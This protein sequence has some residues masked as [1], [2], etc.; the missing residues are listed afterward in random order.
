MPRSSLSTR[1]LA[2]LALGGIP[3][4]PPC[5]AE[6]AAT[7]FQEPDA[8]EVLPKGF[9]IP[10]TRQARALSDRA[11]EHVAARRYAEAIADLQTLIVEHQGDVLL[12][13]RG[14]R[15]IP[16]CIHVGAAEWARRE[17]LALPLAARATYRDRFEVD[18]R[19]AFER[20]R[21]A[22]SRR[23]LIEVAR[24]YPLC[25]AARDAWWT[26]GDL[27]LEQGDAA[28]AARAYERAV[29]LSEALGEP[30]AATATARLQL[31]R[32]L[33][34]PEPAA[35]TSPGAEC[36][37]WQRRIDTPGK[38][39]PFETRHGEFFNLFPTAA[40]DLVL[41]SD[42]LRLSAFDAWS[43]EPRWTSAE[44]PGWD[45]VDAGAYR[46]NGTTPIRR[47][48]FFDA[49]DRRSLVVRPAAGGGV[50]VAALQIPVSHGYRT[51]FQNYAIT[52]IIPDRR[53]FAFELESGRE[54][55]NHVPPTTWDGESGSFT[56]RMRV[57]GP[58]VISGG[59]VLAPVY[60]MQG[61]VEMHVACFDLYDGALLW[62]T[63]LVSGQ[64]E[65]NMFG[66]QQREFS[67][68]PVALA[69]DRAIALTQ[70]GAIAALDLE[71]GEILW[72]TLYD[73]IELPPNEGFGPR[74]PREQHWANG[75]ALIA[76]GVAIAAPIDSRFVIGLDL[77]TGK[78]LW[79]RPYTTF[80]K[81]R[82]SDTL[83]TLLGAE[84]DTLWIGGRKI[85]AARSLAGLASAPGPAVVAES[86]DL[87]ETSGPRPRAALTATHVIVPTPSRRVA[88]ERDGLGD[89]DPRLSA[90]WGPTAMQGNAVAAHGAIYFAS[91][92]YL[93]GCVDWSQLERRLRERL[94][95][96]ADDP[97]AA[98]DLARMLASRA[99]IAL[100]EARAR[101]AQAGLAEA[102]LLLDRFAATADGGVRSEIDAQRSDLEY[103]S[104]RAAL[105]LADTPRALSHFERSAELAPEASGAA[106]ALVARAEVHAQR[107][108]FGEELAVLDQL[109]ARCGA[110]PM[111][112][113]WWRAGGAA[114]FALDSE[115]AARPSVALWTAIE[116]ALAY[117]AAGDLARELEALHEIVALHGDARVPERPGRDSGEPPAIR[118]PPPRASDRIARLLE[119]A[120]RTAYAPFEA[121]ARALL[122]QARSRGDLHGLERVIRL[123]PHSESAREASV[124][125]MRAALDAG[126]SPAVVALAERRIPDSW[127]PAR[128]QPDEID[129]LLALRAALEDLGNADL[130]RALL[131]KLARHHPEHPSSLSRDRGATLGALAAALPAEAAPATSDQRST[132]DASSSAVS[133]LRG[134]FFALGTLSPDGS[135][136]RQLALFGR[137]DL[138]EDLV[139]AFDAAAPA[140][141]LWS[142]GVGRGG[143]D[144]RRPAAC[145]GG[146][147]LVSSATGVRAIDPASGERRWLFDS[148]REVVLDARASSG[149][150]LLALRNEAGDSARW[151]ALDA[152]AGLELWTRPLPPGALLPSVAGDTRAA[153]FASAGQSA[154]RALVVDL[155]T[156]SEECALDVG[157]QVAAEDAAGAWIEGSRLVLPLFP[158][159][160]GPAPDLDCVLGFDLVSGRRAWRVASDEEREFDSVVRCGEAA[161]L[162][163]LPVARP[164]GA[165]GTLLE[166]DT[167]L[168][169]VRRLQNVAF[170]TD[171]VIAGVPRHSVTDL[172]GPWLI[173]RSTLPGGRETCLRGIHLPYGERWQYELKVAPAQFYN[174][175]PMPLPALSQSTL[176][177]AYSDWI[178]TGS[179]VQAQNTTLLLLDRNNGVLRERGALPRELGPADG[180][181][182]ATSG[183]ALWISGKEALYVRSPP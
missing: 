16:G 169:A 92:R 40:G 177:V 81:Q 35:P 23:A 69:G 22:L 120:G 104:G 162:V 182:L 24:R 128:A 131:A 43:G 107:G 181:D 95:L 91:S 39:A 134:S 151:L 8:D 152:T 170:A 126:D 114:R 90:E 51:D 76:G 111:P 73:Q 1:A 36:H 12:E 103:A 123:Y 56:E 130:A 171:D 168:G 144:E 31:A 183:G 63:A 167:R 4:A 59:R 29:E 34:E 84:G 67:C 71:S 98:L 65:L 113:E 150:A 163:F 53:L 122:E 80:A 124:E 141:P 132:F 20:A 78:I 79:S 159:R 121:R 118:T 75:P 5:A 86:A 77:A 165:S 116:R 27:E 6:A 47:A 57:A 74:T 58:P 48:D 174:G 66:R 52:S 37:T 164:G 173:V 26:L 85:V 117:D 54:L 142:C 99:E 149:V 112:D 147:V 135:G 21:R 28:S 3:P 89:Q 178:R 87:A 49:L 13:P 105:E 138:G 10:D 82:A 33:R 93:S 14:Q 9:A 44:A 50:A 133:V 2:L 62:S 17:L 41:F 156:G 136:G 109:E 179:S 100:E 60:R 83:L 137:R 94:A 145:A 45:A 146:S 160:S 161:Y 30:S 157:A 155:F 15:A 154:C 119:D 70:L 125:R 101:E 166:L 96:A 108:D 148:G 55:W 11:R 127:S 25:A 32:S 102:L 143:L 115:R 175:G 19:E 139:I 64:L 176:V 61:R 158:K 106:R 129:A 46:P 42:T 88:L 140:R 110:E 153:V 72:E 97:D 180:C 38:P 7:L 18:A 172:G 68:A